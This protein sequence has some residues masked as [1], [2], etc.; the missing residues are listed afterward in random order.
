M[1]WIACIFALCCA[2]PAT[3]AASGSLAADSPAA[4]DLARH[5]VDASGSANL[6][7]F[8]HGYDPAYLA[9]MANV[10]SHGNDAVLVQA[11]REAVAAG[12]PAFREAMAKAYA[13]A[14]SEDMIR[15]AAAF[16]D[17]PAGKAARKNQPVI[18]QRRKALAEIAWPRYRALY[19]ASLCQAV[20]CVSKPTPDPGPI[21]WRPLAATPASIDAAEAYLRA[22]EGDGQPNFELTADETGALVNELLAFRRANPSVPQ[23]AYDGAA[24]QARDAAAAQI[25]PGYR[26]QIVLLY[27][28]LFTPA[29]LQAMASH[30]KEIGRQMPNMLGMMQLGRVIGTAQRTL[31]ADIRTR[32][33]RKTA[34]K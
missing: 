15:V 2:G 10:A 7:D 29:D 26:R 13:A 32:Y 31:Y 33:C 8:T 20:A 18:E 28:S 30:Q 22:E 27:A 19:E 25:G 24:K 11:A 1:R 6:E 16:E 34:C 12:K 3:L 21:S 4:L 14:Y 23:S 5:L 17:S 9:L